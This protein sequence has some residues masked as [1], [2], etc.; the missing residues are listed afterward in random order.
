MDAGFV[1]RKKNGIAWHSCLAMEELGFRHGFSTR[2]GGI[3]GDAGSSLNLGCT[4]WDS[5]ERVSANRRLF[6]SALNLERARLATLHQIHSDRVHIIGENEDHWNQPEGDALIAQA[7]DWA[8]AVKSADCLP[9]LIAD[10]VKNVAAAVHSGWKGTLARILQK[11]IGEMKRIFGSD[12][13]QLIAAIGPG[14][15]A[16]CYEVGGELKE[17]FDQEYPDRGLATPA[18]R[19]DKFMLDLPKALAIQLE[20]AGVKPANSHDI[21]LCTRCNSS[22]FFSYRAE[23]KASGRMLAIIANPGV[24]S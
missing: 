19:P 1:H 21:C 20:S 9:V 14:I 23:G 11:S 6:L 17:L 24:R 12:P 8:I 2:N 18:G 5:P 3:P 7:Q 10:P 4:H 16:C 22:E 13:E 15:R